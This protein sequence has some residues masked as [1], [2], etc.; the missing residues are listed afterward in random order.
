MGETFRVSFWPP[1]LCRSYFSATL[2]VFT[3]SCDWVVMK[4]NLG[5]GIRKSTVDSHLS[6]VDIL[7]GFSG[8]IA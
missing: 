1:F 2:L 4:L 3:Y 6:E 7:D 8:R 5:G